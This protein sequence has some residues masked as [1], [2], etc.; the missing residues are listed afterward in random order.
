MIYAAG[1]SQI[2]TYSIARAPRIAQNNFIQITGPCRA[3]G[4]LCNA[5]VAHLQTAAKVV[6]AASFS[7]KPPAPASKRVQAACS[8][9]ALC[10]KIAVRIAWFAVT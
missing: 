6:A 7:T 1:A 8:I 5:E 10:A 2:S 9:K 4:A 3:P